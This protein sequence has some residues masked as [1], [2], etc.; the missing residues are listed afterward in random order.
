MRLGLFGKVLLAFW[1]TM[2][3]I[4]LGLWFVYALDRTPQTRVLTRAADPVVTLLARTV[5]ASGPVAA[6][7]DRQR[8]E[9]H[10]KDRITILP[11]TARADAETKSLDALVRRAVAPDGRRYLVAYRYQTMFEPG[12][13]TVPT[14][15]LAV[16]IV[17]GLLFSAAVAYHLTRPLVLLREGFG[18]LAQGDLEVQ[19][20]DR[21]GRRGD[22]IG[23]LARD[24][25]AMANRLNQLVS[26]RDRL[27]HDVSHE[28][29]SPLARMQMAIGLARQ[30]PR[31]TEDSLARIEQEARRLD[32][33]VH[34]LLTLARAESDARAVDAYFDP[35]ALVE[36]VSADA[37]FEG[38]GTGVRIEIEAPA[39]DEEH[40][41]TVRGSAELARRAFENVIRNGLRFSPPGGAI[42][43]AI[44]IAED[45]SRYRFAISDRGAGADPAMLDRLFDPF[46]RADS[47]GTG[48]GLA[49]ARRAIEAL[50]GTIAGRNGSAGGFVVEIGIP[51][52]PPRPAAPRQS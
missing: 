43:I 2:L 41:P 29:R 30:D 35:V 42:R 5:E 18:R 20:R 31:R 21:I 19:L 50:G 8:L 6:D 22:E 23:D 9:P 14:S 15:I 36:T 40:R 25:D 26:A 45:P 48:L 51:A 4:T 11:E 46:V 27:L 13:L 12:P 32:A 52:V 10:F 1:F 3:A 16:W 7:R 47:G 49:I 17:A 38:E 37:A 24:F 44:E 28:L 39:C 33:M 34:E